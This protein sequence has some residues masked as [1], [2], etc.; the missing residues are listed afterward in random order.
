[1]TTLRETEQTAQAA[2]QIRSRLVADREL[3]RQVPWLVLAGAFCGRLGEFGEPSV[4]QDVS[5]GNT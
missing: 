3:W 2:A 1:M 5:F 4:R